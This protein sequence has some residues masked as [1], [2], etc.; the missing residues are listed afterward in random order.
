MKKK[1]LTLLIL[2]ASI[3]FVQAEESIW[4]KKSYENNGFQSTLNSCASCT[5]SK[6]DEILSFNKNN[7]TFQLEAAKSYSDQATGGDETFDPSFVKVS[8][9]KITTKR[10]KD[11]PFVFALLIERTQ[12]NHVIIY[13]YSKKGFNQ[14]TCEPS[15][16]NNHSDIKRILLSQG[17]QEG[18]KNLNIPISPAD[19]KSLTPVKGTLN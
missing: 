8:A 3:S 13:T 10:E 7:D 5:L 9:Y 19:I 11:K 16:D 2:S 4:Q 6:E 15:E 1:I 18:I 17:C 14:F 12:S